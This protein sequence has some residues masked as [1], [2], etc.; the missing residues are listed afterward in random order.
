MLLSHVF[1]FPSITEAYSV[2]MAL[3]RWKLVSMLSTDDVTVTIS[4]KVFMTLGVLCDAG[5]G[6]Q[7]LLGKC[8]TTGPQ[9]LPFC[10]FVFLF[11]CFV[12]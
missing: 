5:H 4:G 1:F 3:S 9:P 11:F 12:S 2:L 8:S 10:V 7:G 6:T